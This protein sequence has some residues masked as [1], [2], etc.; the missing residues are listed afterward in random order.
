[1][2]KVFYSPTANGWKVVQ[3]DAD[4]GEHLRGPGQLSDEPRKMPVAQ[5]AKSLRNVAH[6]PGAPS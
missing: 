3:R 5:T 1:M 4:V 2:I 6:I